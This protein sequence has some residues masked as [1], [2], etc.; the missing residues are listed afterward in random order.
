M[1]PTT[2]TLLPNTEY[3]GSTSDI[4]ITRATPTLPGDTDS[5]ESVNKVN[6]IVGT[7]VG[8]SIAAIAVLIGIMVTVQLNRCTKKHRELIT[9]HRILNTDELLQVNERYQTNTD[10]IQMVQNQAYG[11]N[12]D[13]TSVR[14]G[15]SHPDHGYSLDE[16]GLQYSTYHMYETLPQ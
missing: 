15:H 1:A 9:Q 12:C 16:G 14:P 13:T 11:A 8:G 4:A 10:V 7:I 6:V 3:E 2:N 5:E